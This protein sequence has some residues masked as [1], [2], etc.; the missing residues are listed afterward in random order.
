MTPHPIRRTIL[1]LAWS[2]AYVACAVYLILR[3]EGYRLD[4][5]EARIIETSVVRA[6]VD[7]SVT[8]SIESHEQRGSDV[9]FT[10]IAPG[11]HILTFSMENGQDVST[12]VETLARRVTHVGPLALPLGAPTILPV[13]SGITHAAGSPDGR[14]LALLRESPGVIEI[15]NALAHTPEV[16]ARI[17][18][19]PGLTINALTWIDAGRV[20]LFATDRIVTIELPGTVREVVLA[21]AP[22]EV[23]PAPS[24]AA[25]L[26]RTE[27]GDVVTA[28]QDG[29]R[30]EMLSTDV[31]AFASLDGA[32]L[33]ARGSIFS[34]LIGT[35]PLPPLLEN[36][37]ALGIDRSTTGIVAWDARGQSWALDEA[38]RHWRAGPVDIRGTLHIGGRTLLRTG[39]GLL[40]ENGSLV[41]Q[42]ARPIDDIAVR[43]ED[44]LFIRSGTDLLDCT[45]VLRDCHILRED[46][47]ALYELREGVAVK[48]GSTVEVLRW[49]NP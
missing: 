15:V 7:T 25:L 31:R 33:L 2:L 1:T 27:N 20:A 21:H 13:A 23:R 38:T 44:A 40:T 48:R 12:V 19:P 16:T 32:I 29:S 37:R 49:S 24:G 10:N 9:T 17:A 35:A 3:A 41:L 22:V 30:S 6:D 43:T 4:V 36:V 5:R 8:A 11:R 14:S 46:I 47:D 39:S 28:P 34:P 18:T 26:V 45:L 42:L